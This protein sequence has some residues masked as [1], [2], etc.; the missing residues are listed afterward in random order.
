MRLHKVRETHTAHPRATVPLTSSH[1]C[2]QMA[3]HCVPGS[4]VQTHG[5]SSLA[6]WLAPSLCMPCRSKTHLPAFADSYNPFAPAA[7]RLHL[8]WAAKRKQWLTPCLSST[9]IRPFP[10]LGGGQI[11]VHNVA[12]Y[13]GNIPAPLPVRFQLFCWRKRRP[14]PLGRASYTDESQSPYWPHCLSASDCLLAGSMVNCWSHSSIGH[15][16]SVSSIGHP[17]SVSGPTA[18]T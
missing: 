4:A 17:L 11:Y 14:F 16:L 10:P 7:D 6:T 1:I 2:A 3:N 9:L 5:K 12:V 15:P 18:A 8:G 13:S